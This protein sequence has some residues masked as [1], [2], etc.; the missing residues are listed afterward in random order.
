M[1]IEITLDSGQNLT[2]ELEKGETYL[3]HNC[4]FTQN[5]T[6]TT[7]YYS[8]Q[9]FSDTNLGFVLLFSD[10]AS[11]NEGTDV[12]LRTFDDGAIVALRGGE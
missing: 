7:V 12:Y 11:E 2:K 8:T 6:Q 1:A 9:D 3:I 5:R 4:Q 10:Y